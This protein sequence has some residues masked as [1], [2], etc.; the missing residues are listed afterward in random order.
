MLRNL[1]FIILIINT[2][3]ANTLNCKK[4]L[5][6]YEQVCK[7]NL[8]EEYLENFLIKI[9]DFLVGKKFFEYK[10]L[11]SIMPLIVKTIFCEFLFLFIK[12]HYGYKSIIGFFR[13]P[14]LKLA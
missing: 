2:I 12:P 7:I 10:F 9:V 5:V 4:Y 1:I 6:K 8:K 14:A 13:Q 11:N 3:H